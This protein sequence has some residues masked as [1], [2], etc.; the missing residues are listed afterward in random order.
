MGQ[1]Q[2]R[3]LG[4]AVSFSPDTYN[5]IHK[6][7]QSMHLNLKAL[8]QIYIIVRW[9]NSIRAVYS[10]LDCYPA[11]TTS[12]PG[13]TAWSWVQICFTMEKKNMKLAWAPRV[14][15]LK[16][17]PGKTSGKSEGG[18]HDTATHHIIG[19]VPN[20]LQKCGWLPH[21]SK[22]WKESCKSQ[23]ENNSFIILCS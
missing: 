23:S 18:Q 6:V 11:G 10:M 3:I 8:N 7:E 1:T 5:C 19:R 14:T 20:G 21:M 22:A 13:D 15:Q 17:V 12:C 16:W 4:R 9:G 2:R